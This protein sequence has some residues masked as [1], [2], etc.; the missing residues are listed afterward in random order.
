MRIRDASIARLYLLNILYYIFLI[1]LNTMP[2]ENVKFTLIFDGNLDGIV[3]KLTAMVKLV[4]K[5]NTRAK[6]AKN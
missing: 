3:K 5:F 2:C 1:F 6:L 4:N